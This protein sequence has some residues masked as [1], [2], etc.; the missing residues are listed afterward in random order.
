MTRLYA[1]VSDI[2]ANI[3]ALKAVEADARRQAEGSD[4]QFICLGDVV[5]YGPRPN[6]CMEWVRQQAT[7]AVLGNHDREAIR[8][9]LQVPMSIN[10]LWWPITLWTRRALQAEYRAIIAEWR[11]IKTLVPDLPGFTLFHSSLHY[12]DQY[13]RD[14]ADAEQNLARMRTTYG[15]F[16]HTHFQG[17]FEADIGRVTRFFT[18]TDNRHVRGQ[19]GW[20]PVALDHWHPLPVN[21]KRAL[22]NPGSVGR[23]AQHSLVEFAGVGRDPKAAYMLLRVN[24]NGTGHFMFRRVPYDWDKTA[25]QLCQLRWS[26]DGAVSNG[27][28]VDILRPPSTDVDAFTR[29]LYDLLDRMDE[30]LPALVQQHLI[31]HILPQRG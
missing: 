9:L 11:P 28:A 1:I 10:E 16:G 30:A 4:L 27:S 5:D 22:F 26:S 19:A 20:K 31:P 18:V 23:P 13:I 24:G 21:G 2:H 12:E 6:E 25:E 14:N 8:P 3:E 17:Y 29:R 15:V 7:V